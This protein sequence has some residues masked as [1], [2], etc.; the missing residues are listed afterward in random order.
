MN[1][2]EFIEALAASVMIMKINRLYFFL[3][4]L[5]DEYEL[6]NVSDEFY[7]EQTED[8]KETLNRLTEH[9]PF[10]QL[11]EELNLITL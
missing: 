8:L 4:R 5:E 2:E 6:G 11:K 1:A 3:Q 10:N 9:N 7:L